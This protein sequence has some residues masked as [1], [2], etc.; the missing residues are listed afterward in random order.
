MYNCVAACVLR[1]GGPYTWRYVKVLS[2]ALERYGLYQGYLYCLT[3]VCHQVEDFAVP[4]QL[5]HDWPGWWAKIELFKPGRFSRPVMFFDLDTLILDE[6]S[7][8]V[9]LAESA[10]TFYA[11]LAASGE[12]RDRGWFGSSIMIWPPGALDRVFREFML[13]GPEKA[14]ARQ[15]R[16]GWG[17]GQNGDQG[18]IRRY[19]SPRYLQDYLPDNY[20][21]HKAGYRKFGQKA[22]AGCRLLDWAGGP[23]LH[24]RPDNYLARYWDKL[25]WR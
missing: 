11:V 8:Y 19:F 18:F 4:M 10:D 13:L 7:A 23:R 24:E 16:E 12:S 20:I 2:R 9:A 17:S 14:I 6:L 3:D 22:L 5:E 21:V 25:L 1:S 15:K